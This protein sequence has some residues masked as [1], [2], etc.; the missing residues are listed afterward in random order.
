MTNIGKRKK[1]PWPF[2]EESA[3]EGDNER[4]CYQTSREN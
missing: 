1:E 4:I 3:K 2:K